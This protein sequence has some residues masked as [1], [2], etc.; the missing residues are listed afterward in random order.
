MYQTIHPA[1]EYPKRKFAPSG[2]SVVVH[3]A[4]EEKALGIAWTNSDPGHLANFPR[5]AT[6]KPAPAKPA[7]AQ[8]K[9]RPVK[10]V[11]KAKE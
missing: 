1:S 11:N 6:E 2:G 10:R 8:A 9:E 3:N 7:I 5:A 4:T